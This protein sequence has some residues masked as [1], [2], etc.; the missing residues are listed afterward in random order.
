MYYKIIISIYTNLS[1][2]KKDYDIRYIILP[3]EL[4]YSLT[5]D[6]IFIDIYLFLKRNGKLV[7]FASVHIACNLRK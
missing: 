4:K 1:K 2:Y 6:N 7:I 3:K 5:I